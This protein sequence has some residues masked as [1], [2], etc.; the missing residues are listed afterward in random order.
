[1]NYNVKDSNFEN[2]FKTDT[3]NFELNF[4]IPSDS[5][6]LPKLFYIDSKSHVKN[7]IEPNNKSSKDA[8]TTFQWIKND[9]INLKDII[10]L[11]W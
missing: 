3:R 7:L 8:L 5:N 1:M 4:T 2:L 6:L 9:G 11:E 10:R